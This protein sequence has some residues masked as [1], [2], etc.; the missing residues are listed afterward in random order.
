MINYTA[1]EVEKLKTIYDETPASIEILVQELNKTKKSIVGK[2]AILGIY[3]KRPYATKQGEV[4]VTKKELVT[5]ISAMFL[6]DYEDFEG[7]EKMP[8]KVLKLL[9]SK[10]LEAGLQIYD[11]RYHKLF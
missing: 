8:K 2:L 9:H 5:E 7:M 6:L 11:E 3:K 1:K 4:P 10:L